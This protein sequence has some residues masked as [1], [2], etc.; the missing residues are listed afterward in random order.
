MNAV[1]RA[2][3]LV[4]TGNIGAGRS[5]AQAKTR[6][7]ESVDQQIYHCYYPSLGSNANNAADNCPVHF[8]MPSIS[9]TA[10]EP[11]ALMSMT[12]RYQPMASYWMDRDLVA[13]DPWLSRQTRRIWRISRNDIRCRGQSLT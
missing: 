12:S 4:R 13:P 6:N 1:T 10:R 2:F 9:A 8:N 7:D 5:P 11:V 3:E